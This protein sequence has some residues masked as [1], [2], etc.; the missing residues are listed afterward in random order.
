[1]PLYP[2]FWWTLGGLLLALISVLSLIPLQGPQL[3]IENADKLNHAFA[4]VLLTTLFGQLTHPD[5]RGRARLLGALLAY[6][7]CI[8]GLQSLTR[9][10]SAEWHDLLANLCGMLV[11]VLLLGTRARGSLRAL[12]RCIVR[13]P[14]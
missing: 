2:R 7:I 4:Y 1:M 14:G 13:G 8:E 10:R 3:G 12:E 5:W 6:G 11:G 9:Y